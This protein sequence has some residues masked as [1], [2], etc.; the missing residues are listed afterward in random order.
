MTNPQV[1]YEGSVL[2]LGDSRFDLEYRIRDAFL[3]GDKVVVLYDPDAQA[4]PFGQFPNL[5]AFSLQGHKLWTAQ[6]PTTQ[7]GDSYYQISSRMP[8]VADSV[9]SYQCQLSEFD[10]KIIRREFLK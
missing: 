9:Y 8:L 6:L 5:V 10:G 2:Q 4:G 7:S 1:T 3:L